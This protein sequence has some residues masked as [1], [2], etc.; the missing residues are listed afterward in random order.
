MFIHNIKQGSDRHSH[1]KHTA[2]TEDNGFDSVVLAGF[3]ELDGVKNLF[4]SSQTADF[5]VD[6]SH[7]HVSGVL[8]MSD[9]P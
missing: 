3:D 2:E 8:D 4:L 5:W 9:C 6:G 1:T 7:I